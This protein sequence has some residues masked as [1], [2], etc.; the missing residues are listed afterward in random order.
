MGVKKAGR[1]LLDRFG[2]WSTEYADR[3]RKP[4][5]R[6]PIRGSRSKA[7]AAPHL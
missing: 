7:G 2:E 1:I 6:C 5:I 4:Q 3:K